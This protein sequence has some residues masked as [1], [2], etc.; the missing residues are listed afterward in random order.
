[1]DIAFSIDNIF[2]AVAMT[3]N[4]WL[5]I[6]GVCIGIV[7]MRFVAQ[8]FVVLMGRYPT[9][10]GSVFIVIMLLGI[11]LVVSWVVDYIPSLTGW[12]EV[13]ENHLFDF[14][15]SAA[16]LIIFIVPIALKSIQWQ[17]R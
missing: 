5:I 9:L 6:T 7:A 12:K 4:L 16:M 3:D 1:M 10:E 2:A 17:K 15:F 14:G 11:K 8:W 13:M